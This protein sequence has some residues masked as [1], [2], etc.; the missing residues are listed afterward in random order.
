MHW[1]CKYKGGPE[2]LDHRKADSVQILVGLLQVA[3]QTCTRAN[4]AQRANS[5]QRA[6]ENGF[7]DFGRLIAKFGNG[8]FGGDGAFVGCLGLI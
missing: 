1:T 5:Q 4:S 7:A 2:A 3:L 6:E 8:R